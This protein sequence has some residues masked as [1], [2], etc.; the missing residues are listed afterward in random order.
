MYIINTIAFL[1]GI[2]DIRLKIY[3]CALRCVSKKFKSENFQF[4]KYLLKPL[5]YFDVENEIEKFFTQF[6]N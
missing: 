1:R 5:K 2:N 6:K 4:F 3:F